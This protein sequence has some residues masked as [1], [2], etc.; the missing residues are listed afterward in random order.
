MRCYYGNQSDLCAWGNIN[1]EEIATI[2]G[3]PNLN[4]NHHPYED[5]INGGAFSRD[6]SP[7][8]TRI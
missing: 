4:R 6:P 7:N 8:S 5:W 3:S 1:A 2:L